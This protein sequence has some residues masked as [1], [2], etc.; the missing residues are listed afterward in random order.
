MAN[1]Y[2]KDGCVKCGQIILEGEAFIAQP[3]TL[4][5]EG[6]GYYRDKGPI[7]EGVLRIKYHGGGISHR[8]AFH[9]ECWEKLMRFVYYGSEDKL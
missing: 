1:S 7:K 8:M 9:T 2:C 4:T 6:Y 5:K 3:V